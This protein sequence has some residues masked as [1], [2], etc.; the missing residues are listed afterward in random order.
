MR[1][2]GCSAGRS[3]R[4]NVS[5]LV[6]AVVGLAFLLC[7]AVA[8]LGGAVV[9]KSRAEAAAD[10]AALA[11]ADGLA[12]GRPVAAA[13]DSARRIASDNGASLLTC[14]RRDAG[15]I[16]VVAIDEARAQARAVADALVGR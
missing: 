6:L 5:L 12:L 16:V 10:A 9:E 2:V 11:A 15:V 1:G 4:G 13:C 7:V 3:E 8:H 14:D